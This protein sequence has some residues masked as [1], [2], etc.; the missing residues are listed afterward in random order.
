MSKPVQ[1]RRFDPANFTLYTQENFYTPEDL[2]CAAKDWPRPEVEKAFE[3]YRAAI[4]VGDHATMAAMLTEN[5]RGGNATFG[6]FEGRAAYAAFLEDCWPDTIPNY[7][8]WQSIAGGRVV[9][10]WCEVLPGTPPGGGRYD[11]F[12]INEVI[13]AG[14]GLFRFMYSLPDLFGLTALYDRWKADGQHETHGDIFPS[15]SA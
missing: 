10:R 6:F 15:I 3:A 4:A 11:Y 13:Y 9:N 5:G 7:N 8:V 1:E 2:A 12:G 14:D